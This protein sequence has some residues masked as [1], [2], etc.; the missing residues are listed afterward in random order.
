M[1]ELFDRTFRLILSPLSSGTVARLKLDNEGQRR[2]DNFTPTR[3]AKS[4]ADP[5]APAEYPWVAKSDQVKDYLGNEFLLWLWHAS[6]TRGPVE[7]RKGQ[8]AVMFDRTLRLDCV[9]NQTGK[10]ALTATG[11]TRMPEAIDGLRSGKA[12]RRAGLILSCDAGQFDLTLT[13]DSL[14][15]SS[16][17][18]P[19]I[20]DMDTARSVF[21]ERITRLRDFA[22]AMDALYEAFVKVRANGWE[23]TS[24]TIR[25]WIAT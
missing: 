8:V 9:F 18:L 22:D 14:A 21:E 5:D 17:K 15:V 12:P 3:F 16:L 25:R 1:V 11:P 7:T 10:D 24:G 20:D 2:Y 13:G 4:A 23:V 6:K 19:H